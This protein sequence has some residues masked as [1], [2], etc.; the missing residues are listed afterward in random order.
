METEL[1]AGIIELMVGDPVAAEPHF[2]TALEGLD[3]LGVGADAGQAAALLA[4]SVL[5][6]GRVDEA[7]RYAAESERLA[8][9]NLKTAIAWRAVRAEILAAQGRHDRAVVMAREA[10][11]LA[12]DTDLVLDHADACLALGR[13]LAAAGDARGA[14][15]AE[16]DTEALYTAK[17]AVNSI[18]TTVEPIAAESFS[19]TSAATAPMTSRLALTNRAS[20]IVDAALLALQAHDVDSAVTL[21]SD[22]FV[23]NDRRRLSGDPIEGI[24]GLRRASERLVEQYPVEWRTVAVRGERLVLMWSRWSDDAANESSYLALFEVGDDEQI[25]YHGRFDGDDFEGAYRELERRYYTGEG[26]AYAR[27]GA[28]L[29][30]V[31]IAQSRGDLERLFDELLSPDLRAEN[32]AGSGLPDRSIAELR[33]SHE[34]LS[35]MVASVRIWTS[36]IC[37]LSPTWFVSRWDREAVGPDDQQY[38]WSQVV[39]GECRDGR[40]V[41]VCEFELDDEDAAFAYTNERMRACSRVAVTNRA[42]EVSDDLITAMQAHDLDATLGC[43]SDPYVLDDHRQLSGDP[44]KGRAGLRTAVERNFKQFTSFEGRTL[45]VRSERF[46]LRRSRWSDDAGNERTHLH[47]F[48]VGEDSRIAFEGRFDGDDFEGAYREL[49]RRYYAGE[50]AAYAE[51]GARLTDVVTAINRGDFERMFGELIS[52]D[53]RA[54]N[55]SRSAFPDRSATELRASW[56][57]LNDMVASW[58]EWIS[59]VC[60]LSPTWSVTRHEREA[61]GR[62]GEQFQWARLIVFEH[63]DERI[64]SL[65][66]FDLDDEDA[67]FAYTEERVRAQSAGGEQPGQ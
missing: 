67:A 27:A 59:A 32:R 10:V 50:G 35:D 14:A 52:P 64:A 3:A 9:H 53:L 51:P 44:I 6:Q 37:W 54:E 65:C 7:D 25:T 34:A 47:V 21:H 36:A 56:E 28:I 30:D 20:E 66:N 41:W 33:A 49:E 1:F 46:A 2:R 43:C 19:P 8:G 39:A 24:A 18:T 4:R 60:W 12:A 31:M 48:E 15:A 42:S 23:Y 13:V 62:D 22:R 55:R 17:E 40:M 63:R 57:E 16:R 61:V 45:A 11:A 58:R 29:C 26:A 38:K 5:A